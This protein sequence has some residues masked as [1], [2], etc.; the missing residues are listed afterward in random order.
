MRVRSG[1][2]PISEPSLFTI[3]AHKWTSH[4]ASEDQKAQIPYLS[5]SASL[6]DKAEIAPHCQGGLGTGSPPTQLR[7]H[8]CSCLQGSAA[9]PLI[10]QTP[11]EGTI[12]GDYFLPSTTSG[13]PKSPL[14]HH[15][16]SLQEVDFLRTQELSLVAASL[17][18]HLLSLP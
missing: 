6:T 10:H 7:H 14:I 12:L 16:P 5:T 2:R 11:T 3:Q 1:K 17:K 13:H 15:Q 8:Q 9:L 4:L 18:L